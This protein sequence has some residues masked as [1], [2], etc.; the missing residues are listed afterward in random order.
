MARLSATT[1]ALDM[2]RAWKTRKLEVARGES[3]CVNNATRARSRTCP[4]DRRTLRRATRVPRTGPHRHRHRY[5]SYTR[6][7]VQGLGTI[8]TQEVFPIT[9]ISGMLIANF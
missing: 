5:R 3:P 2:R 4:A 7:G 1:I 8:L 9:N 6:G